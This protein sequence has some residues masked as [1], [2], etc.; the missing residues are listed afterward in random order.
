MS[1]NFKTYSDSWIKAVNDKDTNS[2]SDVLSNDFTWVNDRFNFKLDKK[3]TIDWCKDTNFQAV[4]FLC[5]YE[6]D[7]VIVGTHNVIEPNALDSTVMFIAKIEDG[8]IISSPLIM[9][10]ILISSGKSEFFNSLFISSED[11]IISASITSYSPFKI[12]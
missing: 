2:M 11:S 4:D 1:M 10:P 8:K 5:C 9:E 3:E 12:V 6:N 7:E